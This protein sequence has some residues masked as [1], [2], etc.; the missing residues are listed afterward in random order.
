[1]ARR[2][3]RRYKKRSPGKSIFLILIL[4]LIG[5]GGYGYITY[6][7]GEK[8]TINVNNLP[9]FI[10]KETKLSFDVADTKSGLRNIN[11]RVIQGDREKEVFS[12]QYPSVS[13]SPSTSA[14]KKTIEVDLNPK[15]LGLKEGKATITI[16][17][18]DYSYR[19]MLKG[20]LSEL[21]HTVIID[22]KPPKINIL[23][24][25]RY[26]K[27]GGAGIVLYRVDDSVKQGV[28]I[29]GYYHPGFPLTDASEN[30]YISYIALHYST[31]TISESAVIAVDSAGNRTVKPFLPVLKK[32]N[33]K[34]DRINIPDS[35]LARKIPE[36]SERYPEMEGDT[37]Q[38]YLYTNRAVRKMNNDKIHDL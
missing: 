21:S 26:I 7:E 13:Q 24:S 2:L 38:Q 27:P 1:M 3:N 12:K 18:R 29:N 33:Q 25:E 15:T 22:T 36:F 31:D 34:K 4:L 10:G 32:A 37:I 9:D 5:A 17:V 14:N 20:N 30:K 35:F 28:M 23:H 16:Q 11:I 6:F 8:P 19:D